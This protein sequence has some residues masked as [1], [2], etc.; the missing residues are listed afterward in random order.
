MNRLDVTVVADLARP[1]RRGDRVKR[2]EFMAL[3]GG[4]AAWPLT[5]RAEQ[6]ERMRC[7]GVLMYTT[8]DEPVSQA[9]LRGLGQVLE[10]YENV[11]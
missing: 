10:S 8:P 1:R 6:P 2:R 11:D 7:I 3:L 5:A 9:R 4:A